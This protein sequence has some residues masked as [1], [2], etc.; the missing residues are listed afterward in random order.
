MDII[1]SIVGGRPEAGGVIAGMGQH[2][3]AIA[4]RGAAIARQTR[5][6]CC[7]VEDQRRLCAAFCKVSVM[8]WSLLHPF[9]LALRGGIR[10]L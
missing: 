10:L 5:A 7:L 6:P 1:L 9:R 4:A 3:S 2:A 8:A